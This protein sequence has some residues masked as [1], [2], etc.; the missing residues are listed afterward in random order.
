MN[1]KLHRNIWRFIR[2][3]Q[4]TYKNKLAALAMLAIGIVSAK[5]SGDGTFM[6]FVLVFG[7]PLFFSKRDWFYNQED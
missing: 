5:M 3:M 1:K 7:L 6:M 4:V 2:H